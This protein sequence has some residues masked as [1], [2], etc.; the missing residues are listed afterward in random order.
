MA[1]C[2]CACVYTWMSISHLKAAPTAASSS[3]QASNVN[4]VSQSQNEW[5]QHTRWKVKLL[6]MKCSYLCRYTPSVG[7]YPHTNTHAQR[8][9]HTE[10][11]TQTEIHTHTHPT[12]LIQQRVDERAFSCSW[13]TGDE[14][15]EDGR[16][17]ECWVSERGCRECG[18]PTGRQQKTSTS[19][20]FRRA[21][22]T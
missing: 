4:M 22:S 20:K 21:L 8:H 5:Q 6:L 2:V 17:G 13:M 15:G 14:K 16:M 10:G 18:R 9:T 11:Q 7:T 12:F 3:V 19:P 1:W